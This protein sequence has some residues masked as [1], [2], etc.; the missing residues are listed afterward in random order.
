MLRDPELV[1][2]RWARFLGTLLNS[3]SDKLKLDIIEELPQWPITHAL[4]VEPTENELIGALRS[5]ANAKAVGPDELPVEL[6]KLGINN[7]PTVLRV[8]HLVIKRVWH[9]REVPKR[10][11]DAVIKVLH[12][13]KDR[14]ECGNYRGISLVAHA[15]KVLLKIVATRLSAYCEELA[16]GRAVWVPPTP[17]DDG[18]DVCD[19]KATRVGKEARAPL[20]LC[21]I[22]L[23]KAYDSVDRT[24][25]WQV[26]ARFG[27]PPQ[28]IEVIRQFHDGMRACVRS[29][30][31]R[32]SEWF[33]VAQGLR[34]GCVLSPLLF[35]VFFA[36]ILRIVLE[37]FS[38]DAGILA[39]LVHL[40][41]QPSK[42]GPETA[43]ECV[44]RAIWGMLYADDACIVSRSTRG[45]G[46]MMAVFV[47]VFG[48][49]G[50][51][52]SESK[53]ETMC[54]PIPRAPATKIVFNA[55]GQQH[56]QTTSCTYLGGTVTEMPNLSDEIDRRIR[57]G[58]MGF[59]RYKRELYDLPKASLLPLKARMVRSEVVEALLYGCVT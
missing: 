16:A 12:K 11:R 58:W 55:T 44:R 24:L 14:F 48:A 51:T 39:D 3:K 20:F 45:L 37:R 7:D 41:E 32:C 2:G 8:F 18:D 42:V 21:F 36:A 10:W 22:D 49:F 9:Q 52:I 59:K 47:E 46:R 57:S 40:H 23:Q 56:R 19:P 50:L 29:D 35:N 34:Q 26:L 33:E 6:L 1:R 25:L 4:G 43:L 30:D 31:G 28:M 15:G 5:M 38:K 13:K 53:T 54:M 17:F 27:T